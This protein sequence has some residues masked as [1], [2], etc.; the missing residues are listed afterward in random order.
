MQF[1][2]CTSL[3]TGDHPEDCKKPQNDQ[4][5]DFKTKYIKVISNFVLEVKHRKSEKLR[6]CCTEQQ[7][8]E[9]QEW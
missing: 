5:R 1:F 3:K 6:F 4:K 8:Y 7:V 9:V 2:I